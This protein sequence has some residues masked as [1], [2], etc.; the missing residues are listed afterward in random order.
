MRSPRLP[1]P[2]TMAETTSGKFAT[3]GTPVRTKLPSLPVE[4]A[5]LQPVSPASKLPFVRVRLARA[6]P[7]PTTAAMSPS[8]RKTLAA[9]TVELHFMI[10][11]P[12]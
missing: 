11:S 7:G 2:E 8:V 10:R 5:R 3:V 6:S 1:T 9:A 12:E 4:L